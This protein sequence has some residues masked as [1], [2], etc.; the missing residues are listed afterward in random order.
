M[1][2]LRQLLEI[3]VFSVLDHV[4]VILPGTMPIIVAIQM[5]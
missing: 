1:C 5:Q 3:D 2:L 4:V